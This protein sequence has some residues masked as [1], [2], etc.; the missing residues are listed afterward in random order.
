MNEHASPE[1]IKKAY[2]NLAFR[3]HPDRSPGNEET[4][5]EI[6]EAYA[7][8]SNPAKRGEYDSLRQRYGGFARDRF[9]QTYTE[10]DIFRGSDIGR[11]FEELSRAFGLNSPEDIFSR[12]SFYGPRYQTFEWKGSGLSG[13]GF[14]FYGPAG[15]TFQ[16]R[17]RASALRRPE[18]A[19]GGGRPFLS[20]F[21][22]RGLGL[23]QKLAAKKLGLDLPE[24]GRDLHDAIGITRGEASAGEKVRYSCRK[25]GRVRNLLV[26]V[27]SGIKE[28]QKIR[29]RGLGGKGKQGGEAGD[30]YLTVKFRTPLGE[31][32]RG[33]FR[34]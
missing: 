32:I 28:G 19:T 13:A 12:S 23:F 29:L 8:L 20:A 7:V 9:R 6:N 34:K 16:D 11:I 22:L 4:M 18:Q 24:R 17:L 27:P 3:Y 1:E 30:L 14:F 5:K 33:L 10:Q 25:D 26:S 2:R 31:K 21:I 15:R